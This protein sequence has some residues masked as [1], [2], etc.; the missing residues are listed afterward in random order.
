[1]YWHVCASCPAGVV[2]VI[3][4]VTPP[5]TSS[6]GG[7]EVVPDDEHAAAPVRATVN[8][9]TLEIMMGL[10][11]RGRPARWRVRFK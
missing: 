10:L 7:D 8:T 1:M 4:R 11:A 3:D 2:V 6:A 5:D 9:R